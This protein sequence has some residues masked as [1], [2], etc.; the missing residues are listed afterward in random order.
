M[1]D[2]EHEAYIKLLKAKRRWINAQAV[3]TIG[4][5]LLVLFICLF[6]CLAPMVIGSF[7]P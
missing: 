5:P 3:A 4:V 2:Q 6:G 7:R 1:T